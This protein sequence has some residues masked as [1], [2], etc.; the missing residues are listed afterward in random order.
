MTSTWSRQGELVIIIRPAQNRTQ[1][2]GGNGSDWAR[3]DNSHTGHEES[4][5]DSEKDLV[6]EGL[7]SND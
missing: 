4:T 2:P 5:V 1:A 7:T 3:Q 6:A